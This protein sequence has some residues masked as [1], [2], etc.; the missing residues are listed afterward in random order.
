MSRSRYLEYS[1]C[2]RIDYKNYVRTF[3]KKVRT[4][5]GVLLSK[6]GTKYSEEIKML[7]SNVLHAKSKNCRR[8]SYTRDK[9][10]FKDTKVSYSKL[11]SLVDVLHK[12]NLFVNK[13]GGISEYDE[14][15]NI[16]MV[17]HASVL[18]I[19][20]KLVEMLEGTIDKIP[21]KDILQIKKS[22]MVVI[23]KDGVVLE[24]KGNKEKGELEDFMQ[25][26]NEVIGTKRIT[27]EVEDNERTNIE[28]IIYKRSFI[29]DLQ[30]GGRY[31]D[32]N[33]FM[34]TMPQ[35]YRQTLHIDNEGVCE[36]DYSSLHPM[37]LYTMN[38][39]YCVAEFK[40]YI[41]HDLSMLEIDNDK[42]EKYREVSG[43]E[44]YDPIRNLCKLTLLCCLNCKSQKSVSAAIYTK[45]TREKNNI[46]GKWEENHEDYVLSF[47]GIT[48]IK[49][50]LDI[51]KQLEDLNQGICNEFFQGLGTTLQRMD[52][53]IATYVI[54]HFMERGEMVLSWHD[55]FIVRK[56]LEKELYKTMQEAYS[57]VLGTTINC[58]IDKKY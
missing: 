32:L 30:H 57:K 40:P 39:A 3:S 49:S 53:D 36:L 11:I 5:E 14:E 7:L 26:Y 55:S 8:L 43:D 9:N 12:D 52:S 29:N 34:S 38:N 31:Y 16:P 22:S 18:F 58:R 13:V 47:Y 28:N 21:K 42:I 2:I 44:N 46:F 23:K 27:V 10:N 19:T 54:E 35:R 56:S 45:Y 25:N 33:G 24:L 17:C 15:L 4:V 1:N 41:I 6:Y 48:R 50:V 37:M 51:V 20:N